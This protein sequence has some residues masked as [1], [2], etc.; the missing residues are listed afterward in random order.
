MRL[1]TFARERCASSPFSFRFRCARTC[2]RESAFGYRTSG[3]DA[4]YRG[5]RQTGGDEISRKRSGLTRST[6]I[7]PPLRGR[8][9]PPLDVVGLLSRI[10]KLISP[11]RRRERE[12]RHESNFLIRAHSTG[13]A[14]NE[15]ATSPFDPP[16]CPGDKYSARR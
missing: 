4:R 5:I 14:G 16:D 15:V 9:F 13:P 3:F 11:G 10:E 2:S 1:I 8:C 6:E 7:V 12:A